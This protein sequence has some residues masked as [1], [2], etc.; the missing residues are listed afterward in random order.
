MKKQI[1]GGIAVLAI[2]AVAAFNVNMNDM[3][4]KEHSSLTL[5][6]IE[7]QAGFWETIEGAIN[8]PSLGWSCPTPMHGNV[9]WDKYIWM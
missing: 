7:A 9:Q 3:Q 1:L 2:A 6:S 5:N 4:S 8:C